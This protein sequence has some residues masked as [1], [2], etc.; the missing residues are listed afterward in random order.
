MGLVISLIGLITLAEYLFSVDLWI[1]RLFLTE[2]IAAGL[3][4]GRPSP[5]T[6]VN[7]VLLG[8][9]IVLHDLRALPIRLGQA[10]LL[11]VSVNAIV[12]LTG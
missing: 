6:A 4:A 5:Q 2:A 12:A 10:C 3:R 9:G 7:C 8:A 1:D 11:A